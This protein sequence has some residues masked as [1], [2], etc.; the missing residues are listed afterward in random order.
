MYDKGVMADKES[1]LAAIGGVVRSERITTQA[2]FMERLASRG[3]VV[4]QS[5]LSR[6]LVELGIRKIAGRY[7]LNGGLE[8]EPGTIDYAAAVRRFTACGPNLI[9]L[10]TGVGQA[11]LVAVAIEEKDDP[12]ITG[13]LAG[14]DTIFIAT[15]TGRAQIV[16][17]R[18]LRTWFGEKYEQ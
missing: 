16:A 14:D 5:T 10:S 4:D 15:K 1:R 13:T 7:A 2:R 18:R 9:V 12:S 8:E 3:F 11:Q 6:D 17:V